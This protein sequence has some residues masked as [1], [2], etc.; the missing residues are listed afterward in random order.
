M[1]KL[2]FFD[3]KMFKPVAVQGRNQ[4][5]GS[6]QSKIKNK[7]HVIFNL[8]NGYKS[9]VLKG[10]GHLPKFWQVFTENTMIYYLQSLI[11]QVILCQNGIYIPRSLN[12]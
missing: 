10:Q 1:H 6:Y 3:K 5:D 2:K 4:K 8:A 7:M 11:F 9:F 12:R